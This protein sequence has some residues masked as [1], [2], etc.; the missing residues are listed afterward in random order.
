MVFYRDVKTIGKHISN[1]L[2]EE[3]RF[4]SVVANFATTAADGKMY[5]ADIRCIPVCV[6]FNQIGDS[7]HRSDRQ[8]VRTA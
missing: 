8:I 4:V 7:I 1:V 3:L 2:L 5:Q 6:E